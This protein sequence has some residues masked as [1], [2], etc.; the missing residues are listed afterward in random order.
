MARKKAYVT[1]F[2]PTFKAD[3]TVINIETEY[4][5]HVG[6][7]KYLIVTNL[8]EAELAHRYGEILERFQPYT[9]AGKWILEIFREHSNNEAKH[10]MRAC[11]AE[12]QIIDEICRG[13][14]YQEPAE[15]VFVEKAERE[16]D[17]ALQKAEEEEAFRRAYM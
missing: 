17:E 7:E 11:K 14:A 15:E 9:I 12:E 16:L 3:C 4:P 6:T 5:E 8:T 10:R 13:K 1:E 2:D